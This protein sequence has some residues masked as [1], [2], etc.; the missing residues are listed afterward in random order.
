MGKTKKNSSLGIAGRLREA[1][2][3]AQMA[4]AELRAA[5]HERGFELSKTGLHRLEASEPKNPNVKI[6]KAIADITNVSPGWILFGQGA[7]VPHGEVEAR[8]RRQVIDTIEMMSGALDL[9][10]RQQT[11]LDNWLQSVRDKKTKQ[12]RKTK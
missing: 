3:Q 6:I 2:E 4:P 11:A 10:A 1:R 8:V 7:S 9:T 5:L 12:T